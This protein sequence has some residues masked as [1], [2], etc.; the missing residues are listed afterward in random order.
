MKKM[1]V[2]IL[3][4][5]FCSSLIILGAD[6]PDEPIPPKAYVLME[7]ETG[8]VLEEENYDERINIGYL[9]KLM[10][11][12][13]IAEDIETGKYKLSD[14]LTASSNVTGTKGSVVW[15]ES[16]DKMTVDE[17]LKSVIIGNANDALTVL[18]EKSE[19]TIEKFVMRMNSEAFDY[20]MR[21]TAFYSP[22]GYYDKREFSTAHDIA[23]AC[24]KLYEYEFL[25]SYFSTWRDFVK[26]NSVELVNENVLSRTYDAHIGFKAVHSDETGFSI[27]ECGRNSKG[28]SCIAVV[29]SADNEDD[30]YDT[31]RKL[32]KKGYNQYSVTST[33]FPDEMIKP[34][35]VLN[36]ES[37]YVC[38][39]LERQKGIALNRNEKTLK[40]KVVIP[41]F[42]E[43]PVERGQRIGT[44]GFYS[45]KTL[46]YES[47]IVTKNAVNKLTY[48]YIISKILYNLPQ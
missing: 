32:L 40:T 4:M 22:Y 8:T 27:A 34:L 7:A 10:S 13:L 47:P 3:V 37:K 31:A 44:A 25:Y 41:D 19:Q 35:K 48:S 23:V 26:N 20:G 38:I 21:D 45:G 11:L 39:A 29:L 1:Y 43:A 42:V 46:A 9:S 24:Q 28:I 17:L 18:A 15:L 33:M 2:L 16:G 12:L 6:V 36:G 14:E 30:M 5:I